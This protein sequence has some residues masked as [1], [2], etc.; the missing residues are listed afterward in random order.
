VE[1]PTKGNRNHFNNK[2]A[3]A[4]G[5]SGSV[6]KEAAKLLLQGGIKV[7]ISGRVPEN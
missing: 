1:L 7:L 4:L 3:F 5:G 2:V 6:R